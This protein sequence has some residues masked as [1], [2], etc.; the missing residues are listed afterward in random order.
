MTFHACRQCCIDY[1]KVRF[2]LCRHA[3]IAVG[4]QHRRTY[5][6]R[7]FSHSQADF[8][9]LIF[10][11]IGWPTFR[12]L[13]TGSGMNQMASGQFVVA[14]GWRSRKDEF[15]NAGCG[16]RSCACFPCRGVAIRGLRRRA[17]HC[18]EN[19][20]QSNARIKQI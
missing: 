17:F 11:A 14:R 16:R 13:R 15:C 1:L 2:Q 3:L 6:L 20:G 10:G 19:Y 9:G 18:C 8:C 4:L 7:K 12:N 5:L